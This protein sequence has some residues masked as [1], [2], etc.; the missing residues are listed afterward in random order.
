MY[1]LL[2]QNYVE[3]DDALFR[4][5]YSVPFLRWALLPPG[6]NPDWLV[7][8]RGGKKKRMFGCI[9]GIPVEMNIN[10][11]R[12]KMTEI[13]FL[14]VHKNLRAKR[15]APVLI[16][17]ITRRVNITNIWQAIYTAGITIPTPFTGATY[18]HR[19][20]N[21]KKLVDVRFLGVP[22]GTT[23]AKYIKNNALPQNVSNQKMRPMEEKDVPEVTVMLNEYLSKVKVH[24]IYNEAEIA[25]FMLPRQDVIYSYVV[26]GDDGT[27]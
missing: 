26:D 19:G 4:F 3:D 6:Y 27:I 15:L 8:V 9:T 23:M 11:N 2:T 24:I 17:E 21:I 13:N 25:H 22:S 12:V 18:W 7:C 20:I 1:D 10:G 5:D 16:K 14:C